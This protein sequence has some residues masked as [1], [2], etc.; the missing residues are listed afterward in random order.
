MYKQKGGKVKAKNMGDVFFFFSPFCVCLFVC[1]LTTV[2]TSTYGLLCWE[3]L[4][5][6]ESRVG[7]FNNAGF[8]FCHFLMHPWSGG[9][10]V[11]EHARLLLIAAAHRPGRQTDQD[12]T[13][14]RPLA[15]QRRSPINLK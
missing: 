10:H 15:S 13:A 9:H 4:L 7:L 12:V 1:F 8:G 14:I 11:G 2:T 5:I 3:L 6:L